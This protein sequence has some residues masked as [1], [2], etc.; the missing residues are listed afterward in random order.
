MKRF[1][2]WNFPEFDEDGYAFTKISEK[3][4]KKY[5][6]S[7]FFPENLVLGDKCD[8]GRNSLIQAKY[9][10]EIGKNS[11]LGPFCYV[12]SWSTI[13]DKKGKV[14]IK[15]KA[16]IGAHSTIMPGVTIGKNS[17]IGAYSLVNIDIPD[18]VLAF[19]IPVKVIMKRKK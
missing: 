10:V 7:C 11:E 14:I 5:G 3:K 15:D 9:G 4:I 6:W 17:V 1:N 8:I 12:C 19:G 16:K 2:K 18:N 13:D